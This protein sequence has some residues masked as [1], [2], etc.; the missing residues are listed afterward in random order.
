[1]VFACN[2]YYGLANGQNLWI[3]GRRK[4]LE[5]QYMQRAMEVMNMNSLSKLLLKHM[6]QNCENSNPYPIDNKPYG[7]MGKR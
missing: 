6:D 1:V 3:L 4:F 5:P 7:M 2:N